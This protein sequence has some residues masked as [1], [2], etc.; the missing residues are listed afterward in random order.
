MLNFAVTD[1]FFGSNMKI[2]DNASPITAG[3]IILVTG[4]DSHALVTAQKLLIPSAVSS[5]V[6]VA[7]AEAICIDARPKFGV[8]HRFLL[9]VF[10]EVEP[11]WRVIRKNNITPTEQEAILKA[12]PYF[13]FQSYLIHPLER[14]GKSKSYCS[15]LARKIYYKANIPINVPQTGLVIPAHFDLL[16]QAGDEWQDITNEVKQWLDVV[17]DNE[18]DFRFL[19]DNMVYGLKINRK[20]FFD[21]EEMRKRLLKQAKSGRISQEKL[22]GALA[23]LDRVDREVTYKFWDS[24]RR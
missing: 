23:E 11:T 16:H 18:R 6:V 9:D 21:R 22:E 19:A 15:E 4:K 1:L 5:H 7:H 3:D 20:R 12:C 10:D 17:K 24:P 2:P 8:R 14:I 13:L